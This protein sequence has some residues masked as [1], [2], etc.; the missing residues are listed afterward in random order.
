MSSV[1]TEQQPLLQGEHSD[2]GL[3]PAGDSSPQ[4]R[5]DSTSSVNNV[6]TAV[7]DPAVRTKPF[8]W[9]L[10]SLAGMKNVDVSRR[11]IGVNS[12]NADASFYPHNEVNNR[13]Y[14]LVTFLPVAL[15]NQFRFSVI[16][17]YFLLVAVSQFVP[18]LRVGFI[19]VYFA[20]LAFVVGLSLAKEAFDDIKRW[21]QDRKI[22][23]HRYEQ[24]LPDG[25]FHSIASREITVGMLL[26]VHAGQRIPADLILLRT[27]ETN[28]TCFM[29][30]DQLD[31]ETDWKL[32][33]PAKGT[34]DLASDELATLRF[35]LEC[36][37][38]SKAIDKFEGRILTA[39]HTPEGLNVNNALWCSCTVASG[40]VV[41]VV[42][43]TGTDTRSAM[44]MEQSPVKRGLIDHELNWICVL[45]FLLLMVLSILLVVQQYQIVRISFV[46]ALVNFARF[47]ILLSSII[48]IS[49]RVNL[50]VGRLWYSL[51]IFRDKLN[52]PGVVVRNTN[53][54]EEL[55]RLSYLFSDK[56]GTLTRNQ[57]EFRS[58]HLG[59]EFSF[60]H[61]EVGDIRTGLSVAISGT[62]QQHV[63]AF[64]TKQAHEIARAVKMLAL[65]H[66]VT[67]VHNDPDSPRAASDVEEEPPTM[68]AK[69]AV[70]FQASS[71]DEIA[72]VKFAATVGV[73]LKERSVTIVG[74][75]E[76]EMV[77]ETE[78][79]RT[80][81]Y[82]ILKLF[83]FSSERKCMGIIVRERETGQILFLMKGADTKMITVMKKS[84]WVEERCNEMAKAGRRTL[85]FAQK[86]LSTADYRQ[87]AKTL[88]DASATPGQEQREAAINRA[89]DTLECDMTLVCA[90]GVED[91]LQE[92][93]IETLE[94]LGACGIKVWML[95]GDKVETA[96]CIGRSTKLVP[97]NCIETEVI[98]AS[99]EECRDK[100]AKVDDEVGHDYETKWSLLIDG[101]TLEFALA[102]ELQTQFVMLAKRAHAVIVARCSPT[103]KAQVV[104]AMKTHCTSSVRSAAIGDGG[105]DVSM[106]LAAHIGIGIEGVEGKQAS[107]AADFSIT[108]FHHCERLITWHGRNS[109]Q[110]SSSLT[111]FIMHRGIVYAIVQTVFSLTFSGSTMSVFN[112]Y[113]IM[114][115]PTFFTMAPVFALVLDEDRLEEEIDLFPEMYKELLKSRSMN[116]RSFLQWVWLS[117]FQGG[118]MMYLTL[119]L[120]SEEF[121]QIVTIA[122][123][124][125]LLTELV[126]VAAC[127]HF[128]ILWKQRRLHFVLFLLAELVSLLMFFVAVEFLPDTFDRK[129]FWSWLFFKNLLIISCASIA[130]LVVFGFGGKF[131]D[132]Y[133]ASP[134]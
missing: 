25:T 70:E 81:A 78:F 115:Y 82:D 102:D 69:P 134:R 128:R 44:N 131:L 109:Y 60:E 57:M 26:R 95:T 4:L 14:S 29:R 90:T 86:E 61:S 105:N 59:H 58:L 9:K 92:R 35:N 32:R 93:V 117:F 127:V 23:S 71:P 87:F 76:G 15:V 101:K 126:I 129:F 19:F 110:R 13:R 40:N 112:S 119:L 94:R 121:F 77:L 84:T 64:N 104:S 123:T 106:I 54:P 30:T 47:Q 49:M 28:N 62:H 5:N 89:M 85:V 31:G 48:P 74:D 65:C 16:N 7:P 132:R 2:P 42:V 45:C 10:R 67:P 22:N 73:H 52:I 68:P 124:T 100:M 24:L 55:G 122:F 75:V 38:P 80:I 108:S 97:Q 8:V 107:M 98:A 41:G 96:C 17:V 56:T 120:F 66:N 51:V 99:L 53:V 130:P 12:K 21:I 88:G 37:A 1:R 118:M 46:R 20:P 79:G 72:M 103:Q 114:L 133:V 27:S 6:V 50:D 111:Q 3:T 34:R 33:Y 125:L 11:C 43:Y 116:T 36:E 18:V 83:P 113:L 63:V 39:G 91:Q